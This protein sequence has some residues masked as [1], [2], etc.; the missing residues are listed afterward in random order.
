LMYVHASSIFALASGV[1]GCKHERDLH[2]PVI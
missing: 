2:G 1:Q